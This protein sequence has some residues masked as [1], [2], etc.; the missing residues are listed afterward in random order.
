M[1]SFIYLQVFVLFLAFVMAVK[2]HAKTQLTADF[3]AEVQQKYVDVAGTEWKT[4]KTTH[5]VDS[6]GGLQFFLEKQNTYRLKLTVKKPYDIAGSLRVRMPTRKDGVAVGAGTDRAVLIFGP[7]MGCKDEPRC[8]PLNLNDSGVLEIRM[9]LEKA[10]HSSFGILMLRPHDE[11]L[12]LALR[13]SIKYKDIDV[14]CESTVEK[15]WWI[16]A[17]KVKASTYPTDSISLCVRK[18]NGK[19]EC[20]DDE[21]TSIKVRVD[22]SGVYSF[23]SWNKT[24][25]HSECSIKAK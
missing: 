24:P 17:S 6:I 8:E 18:P 2:S 23:F 14:G 1:I 22:D 3:V 7:Q 25:L 5:V 11:Q 19:V 20:A 10:D 4:I 21:E 16:F 15:G 12:D 13:P 9:D